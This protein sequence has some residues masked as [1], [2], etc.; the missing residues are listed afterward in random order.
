MEENWHESPLFKVYRDIYDEYTPELKLKKDE[1]QKCYF[2]ILRAQVMKHNKRYLTRIHL[3]IGMFGERI[4]GNII[5]KHIHGQVPS[6]LELE[7]YESEIHAKTID[8]RKL[9]FFKNKKIVQ[10]TKFI[11]YFQLIDIQSTK[12][13]LILL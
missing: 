12:R 3:I 8:P 4:T 13:I 5:V 11:L 7:V 1:Q 9:Y 10:R 6:E 2:E